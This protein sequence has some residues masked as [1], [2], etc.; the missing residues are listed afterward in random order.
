MSQLI[1]A[2]TLSSS[3]KI[4]QSKTDPFQ[5]GVDIY[6]GATGG[7]LCPIKAILPYLALTPKHRNGPLF[8]FED[9]CS[10]TC[11]HFSSLLQNLLS[12]LGFNSTQ[13]NT[14]SFHIGAA[15]TAVQANIPHTFI[16]MLGRWKSNAYQRYIKTPPQELARFSKYMTSSY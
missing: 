4:K 1:T 13:Y 14:H 2:T 5:R 16:Q 3:V 6:L 15:T 9:G 8:I 7:T 11:Q 12:R 10:L